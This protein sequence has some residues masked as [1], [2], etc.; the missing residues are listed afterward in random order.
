MKALIPLAFFIGSTTWA[1]PKAHLEE[2]V[3]EFRGSFAVHQASP[4]DAPS[5]ESAVDKDKREVV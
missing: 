5:A 2:A 3:S 4:S 1:E